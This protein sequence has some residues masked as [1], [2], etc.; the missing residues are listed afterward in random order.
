VKVGVLEGLY[1][2]SKGEVTDEWRKVQ[3]QAYFIFTP[4]SIRLIEGN[5]KFLPQ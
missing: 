1:Y 3:V 5:A 2:T 4:G